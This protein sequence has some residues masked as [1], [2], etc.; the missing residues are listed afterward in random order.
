M[1]TSSHDKPITVYAALAG[2]F[3]IALS[4]F[5][6]AGLS[7]SSAMLSE[8]IHS[9]ADTG[10]Q[11]LLLLGIRL[12]K[13]P[14][15]ET[16]P[17]G[18]GQELYF[19]SLIVAIVLFGIGGGLSFYEGVT[20]L[21]EPTT[22][23][24][25]TWNYVTLAIAAVF[26]SATL[27]IAYRELTR[28]SDETSVWRAFRASKDP[29]VFVVLM[30]DA[31]ALMGL[32]V[33]FLGIFLGHS[34]GLPIFDAIASLVIAGILMVVAVLLA[35]ESRNLLLGESARSSLV[36]SIQHIVD[37]ED[38]IVKARRPMTM[39]MGPREILLNMDLVF[40]Q[41]LDSAQIAAAIDRVERAIRQR[42][43]E[44]KRIFL[45][46]QTLADAKE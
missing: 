15:D 2:N 7:G 11:G 27:V 36:E 37:S 44:V 4:K 38:G 40:D 28:N 25:P 10:N 14:A 18:H 6:V 43:P 19:W 3:L 34:L 29:S 39:H 13:Q 9:L 21:F 17:F 30:E 16:H 23:A 45:E 33:A 35:Y 1:P 31:A 42:H 20:H 41:E 5:V 24:D 26:E 12:S 8:G 32:L 46:A 22:L